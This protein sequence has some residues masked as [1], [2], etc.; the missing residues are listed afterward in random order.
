MIMIHFADMVF[1]KILTQISI[2]F[3]NCQ[4]SNWFNNFVILPLISN[5]L[6]KKHLKNVLF[7]RSPHGL[8]AAK[9]PPVAM[10]LMV[11]P[12]VWWCW[13]P[14]LWCYGVHNVPCGIGVDSVPCS[15]WHQWHPPWQDGI[16]CSV[17][18]ALPA[19]PMVRELRMPPMAKKARALLSQGGQGCYPW[20]W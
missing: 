11:L 12:I 3:W 7:D 8:M 1:C 17:T 14:S 16:D 2:D 18:M 6:D 19:P 10:V 4:S 9:A 5:D 15:W 13:G 20:L